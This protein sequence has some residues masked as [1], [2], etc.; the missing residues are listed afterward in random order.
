MAGLLST[1]PA[2]HWPVPR[3]FS[4]AVG[5]AKGWLCSADNKEAPH[6]I[7]IMSATPLEIARARIADCLQLDEQR[8]LVQRRD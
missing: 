6:S 3:R 8:R 4:E 2:G 7:R 1:V 5:L